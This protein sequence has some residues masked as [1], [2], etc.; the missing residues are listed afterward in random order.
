MSVQGP[1]GMSVRRFRDACA[2]V[3]FVG[4]MIACTGADSDRTVNS[5]PTNDSRVAPTGEA[6]LAPTS[7]SGIAPASESQLAPTMA[8]DSKRAWT[9]LEKQVSFGPRPSGT[10]AIATTRRYIVEQLKAAGIESREQMF[11]GMTPLG[12]VSMVNVIATIPGKRRE[13]IALASHF[14]TKLYR[15]FRFVGANDGASSTAALLELGRVL[16]ARANEFTIELI[17]LDGEEARMPE[18]RGNDNTY[19]SRHYV[20]AAQKDKSLAT[21][22][23]LVLLDMIGD[24]DLT[25][26]RD[27]NSTPWLV[28]VVWAA[29]ARLG[30]SRTFSNELTTVEDD[31]IP[32]VRAGIPAV[33]IIDL[34]NPTWHTP[35]DTIEFVTARSLQTVGDV[36]LAALPD[37]EK[38]L[39]Q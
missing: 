34:D 10:P 4:A 14:D 7:D 2:T 20:Q 36:V 12:E 32:F 27:A 5:A 21:L 1:F 11:I 19:G 39:A 16:K 22:K 38:R 18:W 13:R 29:A 6:S 8:F 30:H 25:V 24:R 9:H 31:H 15:D 23:A 37:I 26:R 33:D 3:A 28:E 17:F 35:Q